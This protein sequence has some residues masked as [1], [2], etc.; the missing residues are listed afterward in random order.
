[1]NLSFHIYIYIK[2]SSIQHKNVLKKWQSFKKYGLLYESLITYIL[3]ISSAAYNLIVTFPTYRSIILTAHFEA[4][5]DCSKNHFKTY[6]AVCKNNYTP[7]L[8]EDV[9]GKDS[10]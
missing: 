1:M 10:T 3:Y 8:G 5:L 4:V 2:V 7:A 6:I 9:L